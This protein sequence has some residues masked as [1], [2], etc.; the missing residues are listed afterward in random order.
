M[1]R[2]KVVTMYINKVKLMKFNG[3]IINYYRMT[4]KFKIALVSEG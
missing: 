4:D 2:I 3:S 1:S